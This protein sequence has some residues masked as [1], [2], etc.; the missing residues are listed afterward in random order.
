M[1]TIAIIGS[2]F[3]GNVHAEGIQRGNALKLAAFVEKVEEKA[4]AAAEKFGVPC[5]ADA[6]EMMSKVNPDIIDIC[7][8]TAFHE[9]YVLFAAKH[10]KHVLCEKPFGLSSGICSKMVKACSDAGVKLMVAQ[11][12]RW[13]PEYVA[14]KETL[15]KLGKL[16]GVYCCRL[17]QH[18]NWT[19]WHRDPKISGGGLFDLHM[20]EI[21][22]IYSLFGEV[23]HVYAAGWKSPTGCWNQVFSTLAFKNGV[24]VQSEGNTE[25]TGNYPFSALFRAVGDNGTLEYKLSAGFNIENLGAASS[26]L[27][28]F[29]KDKDPAEV[30]WTAGDGYQFEL[31]AFADA[32]E[33]GKPVPIP[34]ENSVYAI[35]II[36]ALQRSLE[37]GKAEQVG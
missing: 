19:T 11:V 28:L 32:V 14:I 15:P 35:K 34:P 10:K 7:L 36:E 13:F 4:K 25:M 31:E 21:D 17:A 12:L 29:E 20:H 18:P 6:E 26:K 2:G 24:V 27:F 3:I 5:F 1:K 37:S 8:P 23:D 33:K 30:T 9:E 16:H 22:Y